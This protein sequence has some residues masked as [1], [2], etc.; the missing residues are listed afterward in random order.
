MDY[1]SIPVCGFTF[2]HWVVANVPASNALI[3][4]DFARVDE[5]HVHGK[6]SLASPF[7]RGAYTSIDEGY[8]GPCPPDEDHLYTLTVYALDCELPVKDGFYLNDLRRE[9]AGHILAKADIELVGRC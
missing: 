6:N 7:F 3:L 2:I 9:M 8:T 1:D 5:N 4:E